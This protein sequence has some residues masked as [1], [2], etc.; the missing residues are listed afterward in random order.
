VSP[1]HPALR[2]ELL[3]ETTL[4]P[5]EARPILRRIAQGAASR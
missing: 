4:P 1:I 5:D 3:L 2:E